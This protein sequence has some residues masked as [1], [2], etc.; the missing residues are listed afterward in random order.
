MKKTFILSILVLSLLTFAVG[1]KKK[2]NA[3]NQNDTQKEVA[4]TDELIIGAQNPETGPIA[5]Y[6]L[7]AVNGAKLAVD[8]INAAGGINGKKLKL[9]NFDSRGDKT[10]AVNLTKR[11]LNSNVCAILGEVTSGGLFAM[12]NVAEK[13]NT[14]ALSAGATAEGVTGG[15]DYIF[16][17]ALLDIDGAPYIVKFAMDKYGYKNFGVITS[18]NNDYSVGLSGVFK[19]A[20][21]NNGG[22]IV[23]EQNIS[24]GDTDLSA[25]ITSLKGKKIDALI[26]SGYYQEAA[27]I[28]LELE[29]Q[30]LKIPLIGGD[31]FQSPDLWNVAKDA[32]VGSIF[33]AG[34]SSNSDSKKVQDFLKNMKERNHEVGQFTANGYDGIYLLAKAM[35]DANVTNCA[36]VSQREKLKNAL[37]VIKDYPGVS[38]I[39]SFKEDGSVTK[40]PFILEV[41][42][43]NNTYTTKLLN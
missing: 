28:L 30:G 42:K 16:S 32:A 26:F 10:E 38:G 2:D 17:N 37:A 12:R 35:N 8:E 22:K 11:L 21:K 6:G 40:I 4:E 18:V 20:I 13:G 31:G 27:L 14:V 24:D 19:D 1:C 39:T 29:K 41:V 7:Q 43:E 15:K 36:D 34:F 3:T 25:Q 23:A 33:Y 5:I 9:L